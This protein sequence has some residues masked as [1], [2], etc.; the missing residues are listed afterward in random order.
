VGY[1]TNPA[2]KPHSIITLTIVGRGMPQLSERLDE[3]ISVVNGCSGATLFPLAT[4]PR[5]A[6]LSPSSSATVK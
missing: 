4:E 2:A 1:Q 6:H 3:L 5:G